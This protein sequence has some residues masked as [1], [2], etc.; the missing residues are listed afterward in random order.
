MPEFSELPILDISPLFGNSATAEKA[1]ARDFARIYGEFGFGYITGHG[2]DP[3]L[4]E[5]VFEQNRRFHKLPV[6]EKLKITLNEVH[7]G[8]IPYDT[9]TDVNSEF[10]EVTKPNQSESFI[11]M[12]ED[13]VADPAVYLSGPNQWPDLPGFREVLENYALALNALGDRLMRLALISVGADEEF[14]SAFDSPTTWLRLLHYPPSPVE[15][16]DDLYGSAPHCDFGCLTLLAQD[17]VGGLQ[18]MTRGGNWID[19]AHFPD[20]FVVNVGNMLNRLSNDRLLSTPHKVINRTGQERYSVP[21]FY[22]PHVST[23]IAPLPGTGDAK[24][25]P[26]V[27]GDYLRKELGDA[28]LAHGAEL[29]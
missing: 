5:A 19:A 10:A 11:M 7:R 20:T 1:L 14:M 28:Y 9:S 23:E 22:D 15:S 3:S 4:V 18:L 26:L 29:P 25:E 27:F 12:R 24:F 13:A 17:A 8:Y 2:I 6:T 16:P 21:F